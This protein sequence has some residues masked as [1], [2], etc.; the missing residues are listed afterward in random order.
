MYA[1]GFGSESNLTQILGL[2]GKVDEA[3]EK[4][5]LSFVYN[6]HYLGNIYIG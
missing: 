4:V 3:Y 6:E 2:V 1:S 5:D